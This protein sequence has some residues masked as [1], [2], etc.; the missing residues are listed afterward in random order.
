M[1]LGEPTVNKEMVE[2]IKALV[3]VQSEL[4]PIKKNSK[5]EYFKSSYA[6]LV[7]VWEGTIKSLNKNG[8]AVSQATGFSGERFVLRTSL[9]HIGGFVLFGEY[10][11]NPKDPG[12]PQKLAACCTYARRNALCSLV[13]ITVEGDD[14]DGNTAVHGAAAT[15][16]NP[17]LQ[18]K[19]TDAKSSGS[20]KTGIQDVKEEPF[21]SKAG[22]KLVRFKIVDDAGQIIGTINEQKGRDAQRAKREGKQVTL[23]WKET[24]YGLELLDLKVIEEVPEDVDF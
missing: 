2:A 3:K 15:A 9:M 8:F 4:E 21:T 17:K 24:D 12:D 11:I 5:N 7:A 20:E 1:G 13:G 18:P 22:K 14:D 23:A 6:D 16:T 10:W 19:P